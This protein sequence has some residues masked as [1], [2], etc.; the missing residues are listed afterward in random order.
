[1]LILPYNIR[2]VHQTNTLPSFSL[3]TKH[4][5]LCDAYLEIPL[6]KCQ[7]VNGKSFTFKMPLLLSS[8]QHYFSNLQTI[9]VPDFCLWDRQIYTPY[10][11]CLHLAES[12]PLFVKAP[13]NI[14]LCSISYLS[15]RNDLPE[16]S[17][18][19]QRL[20]EKCL[21]PVLKI[22]SHPQFCK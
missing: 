22:P 11:S 9:K 19:L 7:P 2:I 8:S 20:G 18:V 14:I 12:S 13:E 17:V 15:L 6:P 10:L 16:S 5:W 21:L 4:C 3:L 1:M